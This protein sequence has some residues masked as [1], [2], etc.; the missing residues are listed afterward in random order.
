MINKVELLGRLVGDPEIRTA[1]DGTKIARFRVI[2]SEV[3]KRQGDSD[4]TERTEGHT[5]VVFDHQIKT[6]QDRA[7]KGMMIY[8]IG[9]LR[10]RSWDKDGEKRFAT[11]VTVNGH[12]TTLRLLGYPCAAAPKCKSRQAFPCSVDCPVWQASCRRD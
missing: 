2:T 4:W 6:L 5:V 7:K 9:I 10:T 12:H 11:E 8:V 3:F 1:Q